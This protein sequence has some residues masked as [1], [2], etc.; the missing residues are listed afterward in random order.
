MLGQVANARPRVCV[1][2]LPDCS[3]EAR[4]GRTAEGAASPHRRL[5]DTS[6]KV[7]GLPGVPE[8]GSDVGADPTSARSR[9]S[10]HK[11]ASAEIRRKCAG[12]PSGSRRALPA[13]ET[14]KHQRASLLVA[15]LR[16][17]P[18]GTATAGYRRNSAA[19]TRS[20]VTLPVALVL[21]EASRNAASEALARRRV[22]HRDRHGGQG[23]VALQDVVSG[24][25]GRNPCLATLA[26]APEREDRRST[27]SGPEMRQLVGLEGF[28]QSS[29]PVWLLRRDRGRR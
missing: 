7:W 4:T 2:L 27:S 26:A 5:A 23:L 19:R 11:R 14:P 8:R 29:S 28:G 9:R 20:V 17:A 3:G 16:T 21:L 6:H 10:P 12:D 25:I 13:R 1:A 22:H 15:S 18:T 24:S